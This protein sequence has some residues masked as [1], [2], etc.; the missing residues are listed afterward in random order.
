MKIKTLLENGS[1][2]R[3]FITFDDCE[4]MVIHAPSRPMTADGKAVVVFGG[5]G[6]VGE[7][8]NIT[9]E[10]AVDFRA[11]LLRMGYLLVCPDCGPSNWGNREGTRIALRSI[12]QLPDAGY[13]LPQ[14]LP[15]LGYSMGGCAAL[16]F[17]V[18][19]PERVER[20]VDIFGAVDLEWMRANKYPCEMGQL[21]PDPAALQESI[22]YNFIDQ[23]KDFPIRIVH[24]TDD[25]VVPLEQSLRL[26]DLLK[27]AGAPDVT[28]TRI[29]QL[30]HTNEIMRAWRGHLLN[31]VDG[32]ALK[33]LKPYEN[34]MQL[35]GFQWFNERHEYRRLPDELPDKVTQYPNGEATKISAAQCIAFD[36]AKHTAGG[37]IRFR[38][39][40]TAFYIR[41]KLQTIGMMYNMSFC[42]QAG[43]DLYL[44][45]EGGRWR[46]M[47]VNRQNGERAEEFENE[48]LH[49]MTR[50]M[51]D[52]LIDFPL[53]NGV[54]WV[55]IGLDRDARVEASA[56]YADPRPIVWYGTSITQGGCATRPGMA[57]TNI[58]SRRLNRPILNEGFSGSGRGEPEIARMLASIENPAGYVLDNAW[59]V[60]NG[61]CRATLPQFI[62]IIRERHPTTPILLMTPT[63]GRE[64]ATETTGVAD[65]M[66]ERA[67]FIVQTCADRRAAGD[68]NI[69]CLDVYGDSVL[70]DDYDEALVDGCHLTDLGFLR[71]A[72]AVAPLL[73]KI[74]S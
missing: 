38:T 32:P 2:I 68:R 27:A 56:P 16:M 46:C 11:E 29:P 9:D 12:E 66:A 52:V 44:T 21:Y 39:D 19:H 64:A 72:D 13:P 53:Y 24:G 5:H 37:Q 20:V 33:W 25:D 73:Q 3:R 70:G 36:L 50:R 35:V 74:L 57:A 22:P 63:R 4:C 61:A 47:G 41:G 1:E 48:F 34:P 71:L 45:D 42:G 55:E 26:R 18:R 54:E 58:V 14:K 7:T 28:M 65:P 67:A 15:L 10:A 43:F 17:A 40:S 60:D 51:R 23:L 59:N 49:G 69:H 6:S 31:A 62:D 8:T 30:G